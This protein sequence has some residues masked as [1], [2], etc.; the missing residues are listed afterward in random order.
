MSRHDNSARR[1]RPHLSFVLMVALLVVL[2]LSGGASRADVI[3]Q[4]IVRAASWAILV[5]LIL[6]GRPPQLRP[7]A[8]VA[9]FLLAAIALLVIQLIP[10][11]PPIWTGLPGRDLL[12]QAAVI[13][14]QDQP[15]RPLSISPGATLNALSSLIVPVLA[16][17]LIASLDLNSQW[18]IAVLLLGLIVASSLLGLLQFSGGRFDHPLINDVPT[19]VS[20]SFANRNHFALFAA[21]GCLLAPAWAFR[22]ES[23]ARWKGPVAIGLVLLFV[24]II[25]ATGSRT[26]ML[27]GVLGTGLGVLN[28]RRQIASELRRLPRAIAIGVL[29]AGAAVLAAAVILSVTLGR[30]LSLDR[31]LSLEMGQDMR[32]RALPTVWDMIGSYFPFGS[33]FGAFDPV[34]RMHEPDSLLG[35]A[36]FN[37]AH[38][39]FLEVLLDGG[40]AGLL[41]LV[42]AIV[43]WLWRSVKVWRSRNPADLLPRL[44]SA[45]L[46]LTL[47]ASIT[48]YPARTP[49]I[50][51][52]VVIAAIWL[53]GYL[54]QT[55]ARDYKADPAP[56]RIPPR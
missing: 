14:R 21:I 27:V 13:S 2:W 8:P 37:H 5:A 19:S 46:L 34:Y 3:G 39:D 38:N 12:E 10:L 36:Y 18:R 45:I 41:L 44:G 24:L 1:F 31:A 55:S 32:R 50:M 9:A 33:G 54:R 56:Q 23:R 4:V 7:V 26:G 43:W 42:A 6:F 28:V 30:A 15:W 47:V 22:E 17:L 49:M 52:V 25:L 16:L 20:A 29:A 40:L 48:D 11:P 53:S 35:L 51:A